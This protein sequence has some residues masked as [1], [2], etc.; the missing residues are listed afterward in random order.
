MMLKVK[1]M[2]HE[3]KLFREMLDAEH[4]KWHDASSLCGELS[5]YRTHFEHRDYHWSV[6]HGFGTYGGPSYIY[7]DRGLLELKSNAVNCGEPIGWLTAEEAMRYVR[8]ENEQQT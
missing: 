5:I 2:T 3:M 1:A 4:I 8:G 6:I 7:D